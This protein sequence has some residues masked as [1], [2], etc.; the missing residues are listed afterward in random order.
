MQPSELTDLYFA[1]VR[2]RDIDR[3]ISLFAQDAVMILPDG[4]EFSGARAIREMELGVFAAG[5]PMPT[6]V[7]VVAGDKSVAV[8]VEVHLSGGAIVRAANFFRLDDEGRI[9]RLSVYRKTS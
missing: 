4:R 3:F 9:L 7:A 2:A 5:A 6:P 1:S 8:E